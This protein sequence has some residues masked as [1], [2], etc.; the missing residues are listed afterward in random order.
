[1]M[2]TLLTSPAFY[3]FLVFFG[4]EVAIGSWYSL[5]HH[6]LFGDA[7]SR[8]VNSYLVMYS[9]DPHLAAIGMIWPPLPSLLNIPIL[10]L[11]DWFPELA[12]FGFSGILV[13]AAFSAATVSIVYTEFRFH[14]A[15]P[16]TSLVFAALIGLHPMVLLYGANGMSEMV[17]GC[18]LALA[19]A[20]FI[21]WSRTGESRPLIFLA[22]SLAFAFLVRYE[23]A[24]VA[25]AVSFAIMMHA[26]VQHRD[27]RS[28]D[29][30][31]FRMEGT[32][33]V[34]LAPFAYTVAAWILLNYSIMGDPLYFLRSNYSNA[35]QTGNT[36]V[37][38][39]S[40]S[41]GLEYLSALQ[42]VWIKSLPFLPPV[43]LLLAFR[44]ITGRWKRM[45]TLSLLALVA[46][47]PSL[48]FL[49]LLTGSSFAWLRFFMYP[50]VIAAAWMPHEYGLYRNSRLKALFLSVLAAGFL[51]SAAL[52]WNIMQNPDLAPDE[53]TALH[54]EG[55][56]VH[57]RTLS[58]IE[59]ARAVD[60]L[61]E[62]DPDAL[63]L[64]DSFSSYEIIVKSRYPGQFVNSTDRDYRFKLEAPWEGVRYILVPKPQGQAALDS[65]STTY[66]GL[67]E[68]GYEWTRHVVSIGDLWKIYEV[69]GPP[70]SPLPGEP[71]EGAGDG[72]GGD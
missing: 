42:L 24:F 71:G 19:I 67:F 30:L 43:L 58:A 7:I 61:I 23:A 13:T 57:E 56:S 28:P 11:K 17:F 4:L 8:V 63:V 47:V 27:M 40:L 41:G 31:I 25:M 54:F 2:K 16:L 55:S 3:I 36:E 49:M 6:F 45:D 59:A 26:I 52:T 62:E 70:A 50:L 38:D 12:A 1:M 22:F 21:R 46:A 5:H 20:H 34:V 51:A 35:S 29:R 15:S 18:F 64:T 53:Y 48:Q 14:Q 37:V 65:I 66:P 9:R 10:L 39:P 69:M 32:L 68:E 60:R 72:G 44:L 33:I